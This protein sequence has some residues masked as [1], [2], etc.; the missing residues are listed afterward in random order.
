MRPNARLVCHVMCEV[1]PAGRIAW[2][3]L[4][5]GCRTACDAA[6][7]SLRGQAGQAKSGRRPRDRAGRPDGAL[8][9]S[10]RGRLIAIC[11]HA[12]VRDKEGF[13]VEVSGSMR[14]VYE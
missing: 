9:R 13:R 12:W 1:C 2:A 4:Y 5:L 14:H 7:A 8:A 10:H 3:G 6:Q 11:L